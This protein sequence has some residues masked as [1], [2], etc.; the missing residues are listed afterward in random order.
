M[1]PEVRRRNLPKQSVQV[2]GVGNSD[3]LGVFVRKFSKFLVS[4][5]QSVRKRSY[6]DFNIEKTLTDIVTSDLNNIVT[7]AETIE[8]AA[9]AFENIL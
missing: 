1:H 8:S 7:G 2:I 6:K 9:D 3:H 4:K 5:P